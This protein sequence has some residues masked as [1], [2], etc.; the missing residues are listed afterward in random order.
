MKKILIGREGKQPFI[1]KND[2]VSAVHASLTIMSDEDWILQDENST[3]GTY[4]QNEQGN[5]ERIESKH[6]TPRTIIRLGDETV[7]GIT[8]MASLLVK[9]KSDDYSMEFYEIKRQYEN[10]LEDRKKQR[11]RS[12]L[13]KLIPS[14][15]AIL[16]AVVT[17]FPPISTMESAIQMRVMRILMLLPPML[18][19]FIGINDVNHADQLKDKYKRLLACPK[20]GKPLNEYEI[21][22]GKC[23][24]C[25]AHC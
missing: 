15:L 7:N 10:Y 11:R 21:T 3:N 4:I 18:T 9:K 13:K 20:C 23:S 22:K 12:Q 1:I 24:S 8:F 6:I 25:Q 2:G 16:C 17:L 5:F 14:V 19:P